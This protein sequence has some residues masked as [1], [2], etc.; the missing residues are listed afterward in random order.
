MALLFNSLVGISFY[1]W[2]FFVFSNLIIDVIALVKSFKNQRWGVMNIILFYIMMKSRKNFIINLVIYII[3]TCLS[4]I[5][6][7]KLLKASTISL[8]SFKCLLSTMISV[9]ECCFLDNSLMISQRVLYLLL[10]FKIFY[11]HYFSFLN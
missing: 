8:W 5:D 1:P 7:K 2:E 4:I 6:K 10:N 9:L 11:L 3:F